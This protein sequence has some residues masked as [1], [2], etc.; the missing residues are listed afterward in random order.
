MP[1]GGNNKKPESWWR[2]SKGYIEGKV[3]LENCE[4][5]RVKK[6]RWIME[7]H[8]GRKLDSDEVV[9]HINGIKDDN[10]IENLEVLTHGK[11]S[12]MHN[13]QRNYKT[14][15]K[16][17]LTPEQRSERSA[18]AKKMKLG[19]LGRAAIARATGKESA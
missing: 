14:G 7:A 18:R 1:R 16:M 15:Y 5:I 4:Q 9:H 12:S 3:W 13:I 2:N 19:E 10:R 8:L 17:N 6:H 11:H